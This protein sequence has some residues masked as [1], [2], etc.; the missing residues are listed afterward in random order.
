MSF[1][2]CIRGT[3]AHTGRRDAVVTPH[4]YAVPQHPILSGGEGTPPTLLTA[5]AAGDADGAPLLT[6]LVPPQLR[7]DADLHSFNLDG[8]LQPMRLTS[9]RGLQRE[10]CFAVRDTFRTRFGPRVCSHF[11]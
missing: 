8:F 6:H 4:P 5:W 3:S 1:M 7:G 11:G 10:S 9:P 2:F